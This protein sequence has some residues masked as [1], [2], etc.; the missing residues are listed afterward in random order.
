MSQRPPELPC[1]LP[2]LDAT[3]AVCR[4]WGESLQLTRFC[5]QATP[6]GGKLSLVWDRDAGSRLLCAGEADCE[7]WLPQAASAWVP[8]PGFDDALIRCTGLPL[9]NVWAAPD[10]LRSLTTQVLIAELLREREL[11]RRKLEAMAEY[12]AGAGHEINNPLA[13]IINRAKQLLAGEEHPERRRW[14]ETIGAQ[15]YRIRDMIGDTMLF[16]RPPEPESDAVDLLDEI[17]HVTGKFA[18]VF[19]R[20]QVS[21]FVP[22]LPADSTACVIQADATQLRVVLSEILR[23]ALEAVADRTGIVQ[24]AI[25]LSPEIERG[26]LLTVRD[27]GSGLHAE[28]REHLFDPFYSGRQAGRGLGFG[29]SK[30]WRILTLHGGRIEVGDAPGG[31]TQVSLHW[32]SATDA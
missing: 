29:L 7:T 21:L 10:S 27:N 18:E 4:H 31:G 11:T 32:P 14:M 2:A 20:R 9:E 6:G 26:T 30:C 13:T 12:A 23:N 28:A 24:I 1:A 8:L 22:S 25:G 3:L 17:V 15:A 16:A 5:L 19:H